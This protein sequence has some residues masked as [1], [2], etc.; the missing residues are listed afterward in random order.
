MDSRKRDG[1]TAG[2]F[3]RRA[4]VTIRTVRFYDKVGLLPASR[5]SENGYRYYEMQ[6][7]ARL[8]RILT[9]K[10]IGL[11]IDEIKKVIGGEGP[12]DLRE[13]LR[14]QSTIIR[15]KMEHLRLVRQ[16]VEN[17]L[18]ELD[19]RE[20][21]DAADK[22]GV[23]P[24][25]GLEKS[26][27]LFTSIIQVVTQEERWVDQYRDAANLHT[28][29]RLHD[30]YSVNSGGWHRWLF[31]RISLPARPCRVLELGCGDGSLW[32]RNLER[33]PDD[34]EITLTD[35]SE[36]MLQDTREKLS[37]S[38]KRFRFLAADARSIPFPADHFDAVLANHMLYHVNER[39]KALKEMLRVLKPGGRLYASTIGQDHLRE[40]KELLAKFHPDLV[41]SEKDF[42][43]EFG[44]ETGAE[45]LAEAGFC[46][47]AIARYADALRVTQAEPLLEYILSTT[48]NSRSA[49]SEADL[50]RFRLMLE[51]EVKRRGAVDIRKDSGLIEA[52]KPIQ[53]EEGK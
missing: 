31:E 34:W 47:M 39:P 10:Y 22:A 26:W 45:Q 53:E 30:R 44:L 43:A 49:L 37:G 21:S 3:A 4:G 48:G 9:L 32:E 17:T 29:I 1:M 20:Q 14:I 24:D 27:G 52:R 11:T 13:S 23:P 35:F 33:I 5:R 7:L 51:S 6:D 15:R 50:A 18:A 36:G 12:E 38:A 46:D 2:Q 19:D 42:A 8:Q 28:R 25:E 41:L 40:M 16:A